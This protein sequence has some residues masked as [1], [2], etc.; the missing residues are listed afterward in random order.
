MNHSSIV[1]D[2]GCSGG[3][4]MQIQLFV[5]LLCWY[6]LVTKASCGRFLLVFSFHFSEIKSRVLCFMFY[7]CRRVVKLAF[8]C[9]SSGCYVYF[10]VVSN[11]LFSS[12]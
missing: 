5:F 10:L 9:F 6:G 8:N 7:V 2:N 1:L 3:S 11:A 4:V 12:G